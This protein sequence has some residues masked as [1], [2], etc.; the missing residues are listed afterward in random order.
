MA[1][2]LKE[3]A[4][5]SD[6]RKFIY[7]PAEIHKNHK[8]W[9]PPLYT[10][11]QA[12]YNPK[13]NRSFSH[14]ECTLVLAFKNNKAV[15]RIM[16]IIN[17]KYNQY[18]NEK[19]G[20]FFNMECFDDSETSAAL[21]SYI[22]KW[23]LEKGMYR[24]T[25]PLGFSDKD[26]QGMLV[27]GFDMPMVITTNCN[28]Q[29]QVRLIEEYGFGKKIDLVDYRLKIPEKIPSFYEEIKNRCI[30]KNNIRL[31][32]FQSKKELRPYIKKVF[33]LVNETYSHIFAFSEIDQGE[34]EYM[35]G[36]YLPV[37]NPRFVKMV[38]DKEGKLIAF[39]LAIPDI[40]E[41]IR[42][43]GGKLFPFG[44][45][46]LLRSVRR[47]KMLVMLLGAIKHE[48]RNAGLDALM[49]VSMLQEAQ[50]AGM[51]VI[52]SHLVLEDNLKMRAEY[53]RMGG[54]VYKRYRIFQKEIN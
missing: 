53:E 15:G 12:F 5:R 37:I 8:N 7:L 47:T 10:D 20:R 6:L 17:H 19:T 16:G 44:I 29:Y 11:E 26:P 38:L 43:A 32:E 3:V 30:N 46:K 31:L 1:V 28:Y 23:A 2:T 22:E 34:M 39:V 9:V 42:L 25:G 33:E 36:R 27:E 49:G 45:F 14:C 40:A 21:L 52:D 48:Y 18:H 13:K 24:L 35:A 51:E 4:T 41:G 50:K 54:E